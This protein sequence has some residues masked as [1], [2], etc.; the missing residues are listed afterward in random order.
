MKFLSLLGFA[1]ASG[2]LVSGYNGCLAALR[3][4]QA[5]LVVLATDASGG[6][7]KTF[8]R[9]AKEVPLL[10]I[11]TK[12]QLGAAI[13]KP[14]R[15]VVCVME[16]GMAQAIVKAANTWITEAEGTNGRVEQRA[17]QARGDG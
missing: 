6:T 16:T 11:G 9:A 14:A 15:A 2:N 12:E 1:Q 4:G 7:K 10:Q 5:R 8:D 13:G 3:R 17:D